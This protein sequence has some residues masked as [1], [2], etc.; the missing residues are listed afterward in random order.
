MTT[1]RSPQRLARRREDA[2]EAARRLFQERGIAA[3]TTA[4]VARAAGISLGNLRYWFGSRQDVVRALFERWAEE[5]ALPVGPDES[6][7]RVLAALWSRPDVQLRR[8]SAYAFLQRELLPL[9]HADPE[10]AAVYRRSRDARVDALVGLADGLVA[11]GLV[12][13]PQHAAGRD[14]VR[15]L[16][17]L[18]WLVGETAGPFA[19]AVGGSDAATLS[20]AL[21]SPYLTDAGRAALAAAG[22]A[23]EG[24]SA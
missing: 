4:D 20:R 12:A 9:L 2:L 17:E 23:A 6:P 22:H 21:V 5:S 11:A 15:A 1:P 10:L 24:A 14:T 13:L 18:L 16:V 19:A 8:D 3:V 7:E